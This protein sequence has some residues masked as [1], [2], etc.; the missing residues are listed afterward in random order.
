VVAF[1]IILGVLLLAGL[2]L[3]SSAAVSAWQRER[4]RSH[5]LAQRLTAESRIERLTAET[6]SAMRQA[7]RERLRSDR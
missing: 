7:A 5:L 2:L 3:A 1:L 4:R 6:L